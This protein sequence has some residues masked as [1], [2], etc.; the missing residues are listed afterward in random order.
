VSLDC[1]VCTLQFKG[2]HCQAKWKREFL[3]TLKKADLSSMHPSLRI[4]KPGEME[5]A[6]RNTELFNSLVKNLLAPKPVEDNLQLSRSES[7]LTKTD[8]KSTKSANAN[9]TSTA[10]K[11]ATPRTITPLALDKLQDSAAG[12]RSR[13]SSCRS[14][15]GSIAS[16]RSNS[17]GKQDVYSNL[18][19][20]WAEQ[21]SHR[22]KE[23]QKE[24]NENKEFR[25]ELDKRIEEERKRE[26]DTQT[27]KKEEAKRVFEMNQHLMNTKNNDLPSSARMRPTSAKVAVKS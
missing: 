17:A 23:M 2:T 27:Q 21:I 26:R 7:P 8:A 16:A 13:P 14:T 12:Q 24:H 6:K 10:A 19:Q 25:Q 3:D 9:E 20:A 1:R 4:S 22:A 11:P 5:N 15:R 18:R